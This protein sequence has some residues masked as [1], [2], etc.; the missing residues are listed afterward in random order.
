MFS[1]IKLIVS[2][3]NLGRKI[4]CFMWEEVKTVGYVRKVW[5]IESS[6]IWP[7]NSQSDE[8]PFVGYS[9]YPR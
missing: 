9:P 7:L 5:L 2:L 1:I 4:Q 8:T 6:L 3:N